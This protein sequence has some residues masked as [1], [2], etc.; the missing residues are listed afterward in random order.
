MQ[1]RLDRDGD[2][3][4]ASYW[5]GSESVFWNATWPCFGGAAT[6]WRDC[7]HLYDDPPLP[8]V[9][10]IGLSFDGRAPAADDAWSDGISDLFAVV[11]EQF[12]PFYAAASVDLNVRCSR[13]NTLSYDNE[14][15][16]YTTIGRFWLGLPPF[17]TWLTWFGAPYADLVRSAVG[18]PVN[19]GEAVVA[20]RRGSDVFLRVGNRPLD[21][22]EL[23]GHYPDLPK[24]LIRTGGIHA[25]DLMARTI[26]DFADD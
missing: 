24:D 22:R 4:F 2:D 17:G 21:A 1:G 10:R 9:D 3:A 25:A 7:N 8:W 18:S 23:A 5:A 14:V 11:A 20:A 15:E 12:E 6:L 13:N 19:R 16:R 26:P